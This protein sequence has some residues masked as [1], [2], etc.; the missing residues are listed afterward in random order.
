MKY[1]SDWK[2]LIYFDGRQYFYHPFLVACKCGSEDLDV[3]DASGSSHSVWCN[4]CQRNMHEAQ[5]CSGNPWIELEKKWEDQIDEK[6]MVADTASSLKPKR[7]NNAYGEFTR[8]QACDL[9]NSLHEENEA[10]KKENEDLT[11]EVYKTRKCYL[12]MRQELAQAKQQNEQLQMALRSHGA[13]DISC[14]N[15]KQAT[16]AEKAV[17]TP[18]E[19]MICGIPTSKWMSFFGRLE[20]IEKALKEQLRIEL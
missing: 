12:D 17:N 16:P 18:P 8:Q 10:L 13:W 14:S 1:N 19:G 7:F 6:P 3:D 9:L 20:K 2:A 11:K 4:K 5:V 15:D